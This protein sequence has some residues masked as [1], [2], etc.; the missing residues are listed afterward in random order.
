MSKK[1]NGLQTTFDQTKLLKKGE[2]MLAAATLQPQ[3]NTEG[4]IEVYLSVGT[5]TICQH[6]FGN[7]RG[8]KTQ[9]MGLQ[10]AEHNSV[11]CGMQPYI[12]YWCIMME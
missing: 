9:S 8:F 10:N 1:E 2:E 6:C 4:G 5:R 3:R 7:N 11:G 12:L